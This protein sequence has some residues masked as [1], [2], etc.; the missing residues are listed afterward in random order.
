MTKKLTNYKNLIY[1]I[2]IILVLLIGIVI[3]IYASNKH[4]AIEYSDQN[5]N[6]NI[7]IGDYGGQGS[8]DEIK[9]VESI[10][11]LTPVMNT[12]IE[13]DC[14]NGECGKGAGIDVDISSPEAFTRETIGKCW[15]LDGYYGSQCWDLGDLFWLNYAGRILSTCGTGSAK[16]TIENGCYEINAGNEFDMI[17]NPAD[18]KPGDWVVFNNGQFGHIGMAVGNYNNGYITLLGTNQGGEP[19]EQ[20]GAVASIVNIS[21]HYFIGAFRPKIYEEPQPQPEPSSDTH[22]V[23]KGE[24]LGEIILDNGWYEDYNTLYGNNGYAQ[25][26]ANCNGILNRGLIYPNEVITKCN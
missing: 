21:L 14:E 7:T 13:S 6:V 9:T 20:G 8:I 18:L 12:N 10:D 15:N 16:G 19:C 5:R 23:I 11:N 1:P 3:A 4:T 2:A 24:T 26:I 22:V 25:S 17:W